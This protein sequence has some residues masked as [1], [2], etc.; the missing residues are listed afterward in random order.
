MNEERRTKIKIELCNDRKDRWFID[1]VPFKK[2]NESIGPFPNLDEALRYVYKELDHPEGCVEITEVNRGLIFFIPDFQ[3]NY[4]PPKER[5]TNNADNV[6]PI[7]R[8]K[9]K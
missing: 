2:Q 7:D 6:T 8:G 4:T 3:I 5:I 9:K 1:F